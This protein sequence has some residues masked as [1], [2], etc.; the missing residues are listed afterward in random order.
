MS[1]L[2]GLAARD[3]LT[4]GLPCEP[5]EE[6]PF[7]PEPSIY[8]RVAEQCANCTEYEDQATMAPCMEC[9][10][11]LCPDCAREYDDLCT[12]CFYKSKPQTYTLTQA[13]YGA[14]NAMF[15]LI[16]EAA[17]PSRSAKSIRQLTQSIRVIAQAVRKSI[18]EN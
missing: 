13:G 17:Q 5:K 1:D 16:M 9:A 8:A 12:A 4:T 3:S 11:P 10:S 18:S 2:L 14:F 7:T 6:L 15:D